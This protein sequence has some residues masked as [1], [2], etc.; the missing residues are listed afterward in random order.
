MVRSLTDWLRGHPLRSSVGSVL[1]VVAA[2][3]AILNGLPDLFDKALPW[4][5]TKVNLVFFVATVWQI[6][7]AVPLLIALALLVAIYRNSRADQA[8][9]T[10]RIEARGHTEAPEEVIARLSARV[11]ELEAQNKAPSAAQQPPPISSPPSPAMV[12]GRVF[13]TETPE[14]LLAFFEKK[15]STQASKLVQPWLG[16]WMK[17]SGRKNEKRDRFHPLGTTHV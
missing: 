17:V 2:V 7:W 11:K 8:G 4:L 10:V 9:S 15:T 1:L 6:A 12:D 13:V 3:V 16:K 5:G 14:D